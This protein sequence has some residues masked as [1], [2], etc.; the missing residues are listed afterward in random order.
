MTKLEDFLE[1]KP[2]NQRMAKL[3]RG[4]EDE[5]A[6]ESAASAARN[7]ADG[8]PINHADREHLRRMTSS[9]G[10]GVLLKL[11]DTELQRQEDAARRMSL[12]RATPKDAIVAA[13]ETVGANRE[14]RNAIVALAEQEVR[15][16]EEA[17][18]KKKCASGTTK[19][20]TA[21]S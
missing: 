7:Y 16:L 3:M 10:W 20:A 4:D 19:T 9:A 5:E 13:W 12:H 6:A 18:A 21:T 1:G 14:A 15:K 8:S 17:K 2:L 11:L